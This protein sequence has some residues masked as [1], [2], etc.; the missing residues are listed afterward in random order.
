MASHYVL[1]WKKILDS[2]ADG[3]FT[4][5]DHMFITSFNRAAE[6]ITGV[7]RDEAIGRPCFEIFR[8]DRCQT[9][10]ALK[11][12]FQTGKER[13]NLHVRV[14]NRQ[15]KTIPISVSTAVLRDEGGHVIGGVETFRDLSAEEAL[16]K[17]IFRSYTFEDIVSKNHK[18]RAIFDLLP[19]VARSGCNVLIEGES[20]TGKELVARALHN[21][22]GQAKGPYVAV[23]CAAL[24]D[25]LLESELFG[26]VRGAFTDAKRDKPGRFALAAAGSIFLDE[27]ASVSN[28]L[29]VRLLRVLQE[30]VFEP[31]GSVRPRPME[32]RVIVATN[33]DLAEMVKEGS[34]RRDLYY[35][36]NVVRLQLPPLRERREDIPLLAQHFVERFNIKQNKEVEGLS[37]EALALL[38]ECDYPGNVRQLEN[39]L[40]HAFVMCHGRQIRP[41]HLPRELAAAPAPPPEESFE[42]AEEGL[43]RRVLAKHGG[44]YVEAARE[45]GIHRTTLYRKRRRYQL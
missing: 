26:Y 31:L 25:T 13:I 9:D 12:S 5:D 34:F 43:L 38:M 42:S 33:R 37:P 4:V 22:S 3:V 45:L 20:G 14:T 7:P 29:Q 44:K 18:M 21:L 6:R 23:N 10:C 39:A 8:G 19:D 16:R 15:G 30:R 40:E 11:K 28:A 1:E 36:L 17:E 35:R 32:A 41:E 2:V 27:I 24:P